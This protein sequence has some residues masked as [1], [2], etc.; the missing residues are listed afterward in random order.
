[1]KL[2]AI[3]TNNFNKKQYNNFSFKGVSDEGYSSMPDKDTFELSGEEEDIVRNFDKALKNIK[4]KTQAKKDQVSGFFKKRKLKKIEAYEDSQISGF[5]LAQNA[6]V[7][8]Q[9]ELVRQMQENVE[10]LKSNNATKEELANAQRALD[11]AKKATQIATEMAKKKDS[12]KGFDSIAGYDSEKEILTQNFIIPLNL[13]QSGLPQNIPNGILFFGPY[14]NGK[15]TFARAFAQSA[16][17]NYEEAKAN[18]RTHDRKS[19]EKSLYKDLLEKAEIAQKRFLNDGIRT[20]ILIDEI[21]RVAYKGSS[22]EGDLKRFLQDCSSK[23][24]CT[25]FATTNNPLII[26][27]PLRNSTRMPIKVAIDPPDEMNAGF[28]LLHYLKDI[29]GINPDEFDLDEL[30]TKLCSMQPEKA[31]NGSQIEAIVKECAK[32]NPN[33]TQK[34]LEYTIDTTSPGLGYEE[35]EKHKEEVAE[36]IGDK[37]E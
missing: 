35:L 32:S 14:G 30:A 24:H 34:D 28:I 29:P 15:T 16:N 10:L 11:I 20:I 12:H 5:L 6:A 19:K 25:V 2:Q 9:E 37:N 8:Q 21:D 7:Q 22:I 33:M 4:D 3:F 1:M 27:T 36:I 18:I 13:E 31:Y 26:P 23:Y 17:C